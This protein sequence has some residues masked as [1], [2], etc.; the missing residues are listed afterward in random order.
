MAIET[1]TN[2]SKAIKVTLITINISSRGMRIL[3]RGTGY[4]IVNFPVIGTVTYSLEVKENA[5]NAIIMYSNFSSELQSKIRYYNNCTLSN[6]TPIRPSLAIIHFA[7][8]KLLHAKV[9]KQNGEVTLKNCLLPVEK[10]DK[11]C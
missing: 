2:F 11:C 10:T 6:P 5:V 9:P 7:I 8:L 4:G 3:S 1:T